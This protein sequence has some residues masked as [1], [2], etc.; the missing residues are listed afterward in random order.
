MF[1]PGIR[2]VS[3]GKQE[4]APPIR[5]YQDR[6]HKPE[7]IEMIRP[8]TLAPTRSAD[9]AMSIHMPGPQTP[10]EAHTAPPS[11][12]HTPTEPDME[13]STP[14][15]RNVVQILP[16][17]S[18]PAINRWRVVCACLTYFAYGMNDGGG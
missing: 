16:S 3:D 8:V 12:Q 4:H 14:V 7:A 2:I 11:G 1:L 15:Q 13:A 17:F 10:A 5:S 9:D 6:K 18:H